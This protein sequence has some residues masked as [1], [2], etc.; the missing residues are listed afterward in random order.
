VIAHGA[1]AAA[2]IDSVNRVLITPPPVPA[3][4]P[5]TGWVDPNGVTHVTD[6]SPA[7]NSRSWTLAIPASQANQ[8]LGLM[9]AIVLGEYCETSATEPGWLLAL[10][11]TPYTPV[12][13]V[14]IPQIC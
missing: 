10:G 2:C 13:S 3:P 7:L 14:P 6:N 4:P 8:S 12:S 11:F 9:H 1:A 5:S